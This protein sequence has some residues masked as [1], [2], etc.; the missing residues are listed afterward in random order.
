MQDTD[1]CRIPPGFLPGCL[2]MAARREEEVYELVR[3]EA[4]ALL[5]CAELVGSGYLYAR[6]CH[7]E[8][9]TLRHWRTNYPETGELRIKRG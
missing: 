7:V 5:R 4:G 2:V 8:L 3:N 6:W 1:H 9:G